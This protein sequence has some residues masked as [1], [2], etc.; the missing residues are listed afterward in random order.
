MSRPTPP[1]RHS[2]RFCKAFFE[3]LQADATHAALIAAGAELMVEAPGGD[4]WYAWREPDR[5][6]P[7]HGAP[8]TFLLRVSA[9]R[10][11]LEGPTPATVGRGWRSLQPLVA[12]HAVPRVAAGDDLHRFVGRSR[13]LAADR[14]ETWDRDYE[15]RVL[16]EF[17]SA[18]CS[19]WA[20]QPQAR[21]DGLSPRQAA[22]VPHLRPALVELLTR[23]ERIQRER[24]ERGMASIDID[25]LRG[26]LLTTG[27]G[28]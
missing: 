27:A 13:R 20:E 10:L 2:L 9:T 19:R 1:Q 11:V 23:L 24:Q 6:S 4:R 28:P 7:H 21:L 15:I 26:E 16:A 5:G 8:A 18:F 17:Y 22:S 3:I 14:P 12:P 25:A